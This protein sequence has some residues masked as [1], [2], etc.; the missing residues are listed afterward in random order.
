V[1]KKLQSDGEEGNSSGAGPVD[2]YP[3]YKD[4]GIEWIGEVPEHWTV[5]AFK[6][7]AEVTL[8][9][10]VQNHQPSEEHYLAPYL[11]AGNIKEGGLNLEDIKT[12]W[13]N[14]REMNNHSLRKG[15]ILVVEGGSI[16]RSALLKEDIPNTGV[17]N[18]LNR[19]RVNFNNHPAFVNYSLQFAVHSGWVE[20]FVNRVSFAHLTAEKLN[21]LSV[22]IPPLAEQKAIAAYLDKKT[23]EIDELV[24]EQEQLIKLLKEKR[25]ALISETVTRGL[26]PDVKMKDSGIEWIGE[27]PEHW[28]VSRV[29]SL[30]SKRSTKVSDKDYEPL[31]VTNKGIVPQLD[32]A[33]KTDDGDNRK[34]VL[35][36]DFVINSRS[37]RKGSAGISY[38][39]GS[40]SNISIILQF[41]EISDKLFYNYL[42]TSI[43]FQEEFYRHGTGI[44][45][46]LWTTRFDRMKQI[47]LPTPPL[48][49]QKAIAAYLDE[50]TAEIDEL[51]SKSEEMIALLKERRSA[52]IS[53][54]VT[55]K[56]RV[57][58]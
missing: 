45:D 52:L 32:T 25:S 50:K 4:S 57:L 19:V 18:S 20:A 41:R 10:M 33:A 37:D 40:V 15:D 17:Q 2:R 16:G 48:P 7:C 34:L 44:V 54:V 30:F 3:K 11:R 53:E 8:G 46:D 22:V 58:A 21:E 36:G 14:D 56:R 42:L 51:V 29:G 23:A 39:D 38:L 24:T 55:G 9:K 31:S 6:Y 49:E 26:D 1:A 27:V 5:S 28:A 12:M 35:K 13:F 43:P 47:V